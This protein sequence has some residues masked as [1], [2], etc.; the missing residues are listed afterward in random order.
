MRIANLTPGDEEAYDK[1]F[2]A[3]L[4]N[5]VEVARYAPRRKYLYPIMQGVPFQD[6]EVALD[7]AMLER[8]KRKVNDNG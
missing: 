1:R 2:Q 4:S 6:M 7:I 3:F 8:A 5:V